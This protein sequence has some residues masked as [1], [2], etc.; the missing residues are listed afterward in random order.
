MNNQTIALLLGGGLAALFFGVANVFLKLANG[1][2]QGLCLVVTGF[3]IALIG[4]I[5]WL[6]TKQNEWNLHAIGF[7]S[8]FGVLWALG[9]GSVSFSV[10]RYGASI[11]QLT[12]LFNM[13]KVVIII[14]GYAVLGESININAAMQ[15][16]RLSF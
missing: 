8:L 12:P 16:E 2:S 1:L 14:I 5:W 11:S 15:P 6:A 13:K 4:T 9:V 10:A 3:S 7:A